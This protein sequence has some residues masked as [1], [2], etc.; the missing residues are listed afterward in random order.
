MRAEDY[1]GTGR[2]FR[3]LPPRVPGPNPKKVKLLTVTLRYRPPALHKCRATKSLR[4][5]QAKPIPNVHTGG[6]LQF[7]NKLPKL[8]LKITP[9]KTLLDSHSDAKRDSRTGLRLGTDYHQN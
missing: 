5:I 1:R 7:A 8:D 4:V 3:L 9:S 6:V 2:Y